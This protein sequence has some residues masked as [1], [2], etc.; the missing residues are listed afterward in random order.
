[1]STKLVTFEPTELIVVHADPFHSATMKLVSLFELSIH[2]N[3]I[4]DDDR[5]D[6]DNPLGA[7]GAV[8]EAALCV[9]AVA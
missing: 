3:L 1:V 2:E 8:V 6:A 4:E 5:A 9:V 7:V